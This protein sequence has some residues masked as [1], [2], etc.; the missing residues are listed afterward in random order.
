MLRLLVCVDGWWHRD[1]L[2]DV[3]GKPRQS[4]WGYVQPRLLRWVKIFAVGLGISLILL[5]AMPWFGL[6]VQGR[7]PPLAVFA[8]LTFCLGVV[9]LVR[10]YKVRIV[11]DAVAGNIVLGTVIVA[12]FAVALLLLLLGT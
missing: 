1:E 8:M 7:S 6:R 4:F 5:L 2:T 10:G 9:F 3:L 12:P 11:G